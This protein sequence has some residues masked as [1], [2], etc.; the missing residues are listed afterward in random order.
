MET[1]NV[2]KETTQRRRIAIPDVV[3]SLI[4]IV[5]GIAIITYGFGLKRL[6]TGQLGP[7]LF[8][9]VGGILFALFGLVLL[10]QAIRGKTVEDTELEDILE[11]HAVQS[12]EDE[13]AAGDGGTYEF[14][15]ESGMRLLVNALVV[16]GGIIGYIL[17]V[18][19]LGFIITMFLVLAAIMIAL[20]EKII[21][22]TI[23]S[24]IVTTVL[25]VAFEVV[26]LVQLPNGILGF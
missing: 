2:S 23:M 21:R 20:N 16:I 15:H 4:A 11:A 22:A 12:E 25:Y 14:S 19:P 13:E 17:L 3:I 5:S 24:A 8:P 6:A 18:E 10:I 7:G 1:K 26:L 9:V